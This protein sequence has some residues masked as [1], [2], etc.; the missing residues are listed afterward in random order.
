M[1]F[2][3]GIAIAAAGPLLSEVAYPSQRPAATSFL[4]ASFPM[5]SFV[6]ALLTYAPYK[7][8][9]RTSEWSWRLPSLFQGVFPFF[10]ILLVLT[11]PESPRWLISHGKEDKALRTLIKYHGGGDVDSPLVKFEMSEI[12]VAIEKEKEF[13]GQK[14]KEWI[15]TRANIHRL[16]LTLALPI[17]MQFCGNALISYYLNIILNNIGFT[18]TL[19]KLQINIGLTLYGLI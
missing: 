19:E 12:K 18:H 11:G 8:D 13:G 17:M 9:L 2:G 7:T 10:S 16:Y 6:A 3:V 4:L 15:R 1:G 14:W 5:G